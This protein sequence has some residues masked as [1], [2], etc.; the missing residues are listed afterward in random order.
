MKDCTIQGVR[1]GDKRFEVGQT[2][3]G[4]GIIE[5]FDFENGRVLARVNYNCNYPFRPNHK[6]MDIVYL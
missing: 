3:K 5:N 4:K 1:V 2:V 6:T